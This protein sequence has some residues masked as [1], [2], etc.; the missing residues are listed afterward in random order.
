MPLFDTSHYLPECKLSECSLFFSSIFVQ[1]WNRLLRL[2]DSPRKHEGA[3]ADLIVRSMRT[4]GMR[5]DK[6]HPIVISDEYD[7][8]INQTIIDTWYVL[9][10]VALCAIHRI[11]W[12]S[13]VAAFF[14]TD[15]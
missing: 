9:P 13:E 10:G 15:E 6:S 1:L 8:C 4:K 12:Q 7:S 5:G 11:V 2:L 14:L 3:A